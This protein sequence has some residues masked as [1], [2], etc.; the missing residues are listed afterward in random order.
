MSTTW[1][2]VEI[3]LGE[4]SVWGS[5][6]WRPDQRT[7]EFSLDASL[8]PATEL[9]VRIQA[10]D[11]AGNFAYVETW[12]Q[13]GQ[14]P[15]RDAEPPRLVASF[16]ESPVKGMQVLG[17]R[18][19]E[20]LARSSLEGV[21]AT[22]VDGDVYEIEYSSGEYGP[23]IAFQPLRSPPAGSTVRLRIPTSVTDL[24]GNELAEAI[25]VSYTVAE[26]TDL[27]APVAG[28]TV[29]P[30]DRPAWSWNVEIAFEDG[31]S[32]Y[33][34]ALDALSVGPEDVQVLDDATGLLV[35]GWRTETRRGSSILKL[36][37]PP[38]GP[39][40]PGSFTIRH[41]LGE[42]EGGTGIADA[43]GNPAAEGAFTAWVAEGPPEGPNRVPHA[44]SLEEIRVGCSSSPVARRLEVRL[45]LADA[46]GTFESP[47][48]VTVS[49][50]GKDGAVPFPDTE[51]TLGVWGWTEYR[52][53]EDGG[54][55]FAT[56]PAE[57]DDVNFPASGYYPFTI[58][59]DD[60]SDTTSYRRMAWVWAPSDVPAIQSI[61]DGGA[62]RPMSAA[63]PPVIVNTAS[64]T[65]RWGD[66]DAE[67]ADVLVT[68]VAETGAIGD[69]AG[70]YVEAVPLP[71]ATTQL[72]APNPLVPGVYLWTVA[73]TKL[74]RG[75]TDIM[76]TG[77]ALD[78]N[79]SAEAMFVYGPENDSLAGQAYGV[80]TAR[81]LQGRSEFDDLVL[82]GVDGER[83]TYEVEAMPAETA[84]VFVAH[85][86][87]DNAG[88]PVTDPDRL[89]ARGTAGELMVTEPAT[90]LPFPLPRHGFLR[91]AGDLFAA[92]QR[93]EAVPSITAGAHRFATSGFGPALPGLFTFVQFELSASGDPPVLGEIGASVGEVIDETGAGE[94]LTVN[95]TEN[96][97][98][99]VG[100]IYVDYSLDAD[101]LLHIHYNPFEPVAGFASGYMGGT[102]G[103]EIVA[104][105]SDSTPG[106]VWW[107]LAGRARTWSGETVADLSGP[108]RFVDFA[109]R[110]SDDPLDA[111]G[112]EESHGADG[113]LV[114]DGEGGFVYQV[115]TGGGTMVGSGTYAV[116]PASERVTVTVAGNTF[117]LAAGP[118]LDLLY[119][120][121]I[122]TEGFAE[123]LVIGR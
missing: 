17:F 116:D 88:G 33:P 18:F 91:A 80:A 96:T 81:L 12:L 107:L 10:A 31:E 43:F 99:E 9:E 70:G 53:G 44:A 68:Y 87:V 122:G 6:T 72:T 120:I 47:A 108:Y 65:F 121:A 61:D 92:A 16:A 22:A 41:A 32:G 42:S 36:L 123:L 28:D 78:F 3:R 100:P 20:P 29:P 64:P 51:Q 77:W 73:Q 27:T 71:P 109:V 50:T 52:Y 55:P 113:T 84:P 26:F 46:D 102:S 56:A 90:V 34:D 105:A 103:A 115:Q 118:D 117:L 15:L 37:P 8:P 83:G 5:G 13:I 7:L 85:D 114:F 112:L 57:L 30:A 21:T 60:G 19:S 106:R 104:A 25:D 38:R 67:N 40:G 89:F 111:D 35:R 23:V 24:A 54:P 58:T 76:S 62:I 48:P 11:T 119:G 94:V 95:L 82:A 66:Q 14:D 69:G 75:S 101:G 93:N 2:W 97:G 74:P 63:R 59:L 86:L 110:H 39:Y 1:S 45:P 98:G 79:E 49:V 4:S